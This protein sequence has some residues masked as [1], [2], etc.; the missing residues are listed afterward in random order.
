VREGIVTEETP[1]NPH[2]AYE[3]TKT[4]CDT[5]VRRAAADGSFSCTILRPSIVYGPTMTNQSVRQLIRMIS[6]GLFFFIGRPGASANY[7]H[8]DNVVDALARC[9]TRAEARGATY[10]LSDH[11]SIEDLVAL[12][13]SELRR[14]APRLRL[15]EGPTRFLASILGPLPGFPLTRSRVDALT[16]RAIYSP[17]L[18]ER[19]LSYA[20]SVQFEEGMRQMVQMV[21]A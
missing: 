11:R 15:P 14:P 16:G 4:E 10:V 2:G 18:I 6:R 13:A 9:A 1:E 8:V 17:A 3:V 12:V 19:Q 7:I 20:H 21:Q 5:L